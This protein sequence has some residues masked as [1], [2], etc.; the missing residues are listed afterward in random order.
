MSKSCNDAVEQIYVYLDE[1]MTFFRRMRVRW[2]LR[3]CHDCC[4]AFDFEEGVKQM[5]REKSKTEPP[6]ELIDRLR[7][8]LREEAGD[9]TER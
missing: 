3:R 1:E 4:G 9:D 5:V 2:H 8:L 6:A 7:T